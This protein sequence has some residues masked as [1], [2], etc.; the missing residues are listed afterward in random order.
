MTPF[1]QKRTLVQKA[2]EYLL[3]PSARIHDPELCLFLCDAIQKANDCL[4]VP[5]PDSTVTELKK[6]LK[7]ALKT[8]T[9][10]VLT[11]GTVGNALRTTTLSDAVIDQYEL[12][13]RTRLGLISTYTTQ[14]FNV[15]GA[16]EQA[17]ATLQGDLITKKKLSGKLRQ[18]VKK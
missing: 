15:N 4:K 10:S 8:F 9:G 5:M 11:S 1:R 17:L 18:G 13:Y 12:A 3:D 2:R 7:G 16:I 6:E 14:G